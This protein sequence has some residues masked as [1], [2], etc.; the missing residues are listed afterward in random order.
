[1]RISIHNFVLDIGWYN[2]LCDKGYISIKFFK[3]IH[4]KY[5]KINY[6]SVYLNLHIKINSRYKRNWI[7]NKPSHGLIIYLHK[8]D[9]YDEIYIIFKRWI[10]FKDYIIL[11]STIPYRFSYP[12]EDVLVSLLSLGE[13]MYVVCD[14]SLRNF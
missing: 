8:F 11:S 3:L 2:L 7:I 10:N 9:F 14:D 5:I 6:M 1:M 13:V 4:T 12:I